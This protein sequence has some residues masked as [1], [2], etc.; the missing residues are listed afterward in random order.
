MFA[1]LHTLCFIA[2]IVE[3][4]PGHSCKTCDVD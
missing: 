1:A 2:Q 4:A 3:C